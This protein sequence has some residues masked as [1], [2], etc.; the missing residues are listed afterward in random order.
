MRRNEKETRDKNINRLCICIREN[1]SNKS[2]KKC[3]EENTN[4][5]LVV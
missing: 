2:M 5:E 1:V 3:N 4:V